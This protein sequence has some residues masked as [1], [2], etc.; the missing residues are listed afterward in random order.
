MSEK[1]VDSRLQ[2]APEDPDV[3]KRMARLKE[4]GL[5]DEP[6]REFDEFAAQLA[7][8]AGTPLAMVNFIGTDKQYFA[9]L[10]A[11]GTAT[12]GALEAAQTDNSSVS[13][14]MARDHGWCP[15]VVA[16]K[17]AL[18]LDDVCSMPR[19][20]GNPVVDEI[21]IR[22]YIGAPLMD[23][24]TGVALGTICGV[25][26]STSEWGRPGLD[27]IKDLAAQLVDRIYGRR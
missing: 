4:L 8:R 15:H 25:S 2:T 11:P 14:V 7:E 18:V 27:M 12:A 3:H 6:I 13:R 1:F 23:P 24:E 22:S 16:R 10:Y 19:F 20:S 17:K 5:G 21:G 9:G 26:Q